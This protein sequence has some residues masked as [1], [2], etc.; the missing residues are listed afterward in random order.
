MKK[1]KRCKPIGSPSLFCT[2]TP[3]F[4]DSTDWK[5]IYAKYKMMTH[6]KYKREP[7]AATL[8]QYLSIDAS[9]DPP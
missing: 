9:F 3:A 4:L 2:G 7:R 5:W 1:V 6:K 8:D